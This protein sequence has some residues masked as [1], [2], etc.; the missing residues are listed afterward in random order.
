VL[1]SFSLGLEFLDLARLVA[2]EQAKSTPRARSAPGVSI[3]PAD[4]QMMDI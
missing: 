2:G 4:Q 3:V 1:Y